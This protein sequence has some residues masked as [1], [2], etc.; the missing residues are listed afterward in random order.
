MC[1]PATVERGYR[2]RRER[3]RERGGGK[4]GRVEREGRDGEIEKEKKGRDEGRGVK[5]VLNGVMLGV[6]IAVS[7][8]LA[9]SPEAVWLSTPCCQVQP[10]LLVKVLKGVEEGGL[11]EQMSKAQSCIARATLGAIVLLCPVVCTT[12]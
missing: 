2:G 12:S 11:N 1:G 9:F 5:P 3:E 8:C 7:S 10:N 4:K 6:C